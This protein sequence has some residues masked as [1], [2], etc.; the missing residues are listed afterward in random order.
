MICHWSVTACVA[1]H[2]CE[3]SGG[4]GER[5]RQATSWQ[6]SAKYTDV[7]LLS[8]LDISTANLYSTRLLTAS[9]SSA[10][11][12]CLVSQSH[13][14]L[15]HQQHTALHFPFLIYLLMTAVKRSMQERKSCE[16]N[17]ENTKARL[18]ERR[19]MYWTYD[20]WQQKC[21]T[22]T[23]IGCMI[24]CTYSLW[25]DDMFPLVLVEPSDSLHCDV[26][27]LRCSAC[28][29]NLLWVGFYQ[30]RHLLQCVQYTSTN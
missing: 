5:R 25:C 1:Q 9:Q 12:I 15:S 3:S 8:D 23:V 17:N 4:D 14:P 16:H 26:V 2:K 10:Q 27:T 24:G 6:S 19:M 18:D 21:K 20:V 30:L 13:Q 7:K 11:R 29:H 28:E 22:E